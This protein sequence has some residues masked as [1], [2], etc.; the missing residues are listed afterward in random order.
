[1]ATHDGYPHFEVCLSETDEPGRR[2]GHPGSLF[3]FIGVLRGF[4]YRRPDDVF[5]DPGRSSHAHDLGL[6]DGSAE[7]LIGRKKRIRTNLTEL[8]PEYLLDAVNGVKERAAID[9]E[10]PATK[11][12]IRS[13]EEMKAKETKFVLGQHAT[14]DQVEVGHIVFAGAGPSGVGVVPLAGHQHNFTA[15]RFIVGAKIESLQTRPKDV[16]QD[17]VARRF[18]IAVWSWTEAGAL[19]FDASHIGESNRFRMVPLHG[20]CRIHGVL[21]L[22]WGLSVFEVFFIHNY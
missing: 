10:A 22:P 19:A 6:A 12:P 14:G 5:L 3:F 7:I 20:L 11:L 16:A 1:M 15:V 4:A 9:T 8:A 21:F 2:E 17:A 13:Q 18:A